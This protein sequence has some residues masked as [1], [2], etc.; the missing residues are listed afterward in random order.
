MP[1]GRSST[2]GQLVNRE[3]IDGKVWVH[4]RQFEFMV[5]NYYADYFATVSEH[6]AVLV[7]FSAYRAGFKSH[8]SVSICR[9]MATIR[10]QT[11]PN[12]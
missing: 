8:S 3:T 7:T 5:P 10:R 4:G 2:P 9:S 6:I 1:M 12:H 11:H